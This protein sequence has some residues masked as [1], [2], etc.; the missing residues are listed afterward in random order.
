MIQDVIRNYD[1]N[2]GIFKI[3]L[4]AWLPLIVIIILFYLLRRLWQYR[5]DFSSGRSSFV[6]I[7]ESSRR[8]KV[9]IFLIIA[10][11]MFLLNS[12]DLGIN[13]NLS[14][15]QVLS[16]ALVVTLLLAL[17]L[18]YDAKDREH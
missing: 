15:Y 3:A 12:S 17:F 6:E 1:N 11:N 18:Q 9:I 14:R 13:L 5:K 16:I 4:T 7:A 10:T 2:T 8:Q